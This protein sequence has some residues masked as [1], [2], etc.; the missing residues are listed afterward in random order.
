MVGPTY[1]T[2]GKRGLDRS[3]DAGLLAYDSGEALLS[4]WGGAFE[5]RWTWRMEGESRN[6][7]SS[8]VE[9]VVALN[10][11]V[12]WFLCRSEARWRTAQQTEAE[13]QLPQLTH[14]FLIVPHAMPTTG[15]GWQV[16][17]FLMCAAGVTSDWRVVSMTM[18]CVFPLK[19]SSVVRTMDSTPQR[20]TIFFWKLLRDDDLKPVFLKKIKIHKSMCAKNVFF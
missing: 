10:H 4:L 12:I 20:A 5:R 3:H 11:T 7:Q 17:G 13:D 6:L 19:D 15:T 1:W 2:L 18:G 14:N 9:E 8:A 16:D